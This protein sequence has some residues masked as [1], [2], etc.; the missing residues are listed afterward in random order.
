MERHIEFSG[1]SLSH[2]DLVRFIV[3]TS[4]TLCCICITWF[5]LSRLGET[6][7]V[8]I[9]YFPLLYTAY[10]YPRK[11][12][13]LAFI[14]AVVYEVLAT[15]YMVPSFSGFI[16][17]TI[18]AVLF[19]G[20]TAL[21][22]YFAE[23]ANASETRFRSIFENSLVG[24]V[25]FDQN[26]FKI[27]FSNAQFKTMLGYSEEDLFHVTFAGLFSSDEDRQRF[28]EYLGSSQKVTHFE[29]RFVTKN[30]N[31]TWVNLSWSRIIGN[32][33]SCSVMDMNKYKLAE[34]EANDNYA[35]FRQLTDGSP[36]SIMIIRNQKIVYLNPSFVV[37]SGYEPGELLDKE[38][39][40]I[41][42]PEDQEAFLNSCHLAETQSPL[43]ERSEFK[44]LTKSG[45]T[46]L[47]S[48]FF[49]RVLQKGVPAVLINLIDITEQKILQ[50]RIL[51]DNERRQTIIS[52]VAHDL[53]TPL[54]P[55]MGYIEMLTQD[56]KAF[57]ITEKTRLILDRCAKSVDRE[58]QIIN[59]MLELSVLDTGNVPLNYS[60]FSV[61]DMLNKV[62]QKG[63]YQE[64]A[65]ITIAVPPDLTFEA[66]E[67]KI[68]TVIDTM[69]SN[70]VNYSTPPRRIRIG[71]QASTFDKLHRLSIQDNGFGITDTQ[72]DEIFEPF[73]QT[74]EEN[75]KKKFERIGLSLSIAKKYIKMHNGY[76]S[77]D[78]IVNIGSTFSIHLPK[79]KPAE[80]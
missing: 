45:D 43:P 35:Q 66:D 33:V 72:L 77:V 47:A 20:I 60:V 79:Q 80:L 32:L 14:C 69:L 24:I 52:S 17:T 63:G 4:L 49:T 6:I 11:G 71:Y 26:S 54:Q 56:P 65:E 2:S 48:L 21:V 7:F 10:F 75:P 59:Q 50:E 8:Q 67:N 73:Q 46:R 64:L 16:Y 18:Q 58:R 29:T 25:L 39:T 41:I 13:Y 19:I 30:H 9:F 51:Q 62:I 70:A 12:L 22:A 78:S 5:S 68:A 76:I 61:P 42:H 31:Q 38:T 55:I 15:L 40:P 57:G 37:F 44:I 53:R 34:E 74:D 3:I 27:Q 28:F 36:T 23:K 1:Y